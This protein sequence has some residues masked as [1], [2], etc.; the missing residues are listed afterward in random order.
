MGPEEGGGGTNATST[1]LSSYFFLFLTFV[2]QSVSKGPAGYIFR[3]TY[4]EFRISAYFIFISFNEHFF[5]FFFLMQILHPRSC[6]SKQH[7][8]YQYFYFAEIESK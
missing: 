1:R 5:S 6:V 8:K 4:G 2:A 7:S 3:K